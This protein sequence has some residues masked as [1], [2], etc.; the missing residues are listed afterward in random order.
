[1]NKQNCKATEILYITQ[2][3]LVKYM[4][5]I[6]ENGKLGGERKAANMG[7]FSVIL[8]IELLM[9]KVSRFF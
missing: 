6:Q 5:G 1:M 3:G 2:G 8:N 7:G 9:I 4:S